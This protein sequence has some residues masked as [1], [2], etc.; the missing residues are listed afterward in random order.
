MIDNIP[1]RC[2]YKRNI[3]KLRIILTYMSHGKW[4]RNGIAIIRLVLLSQVFLNPVVLHLLIKVSYAITA[5]ISIHSFNLEQN[6]KG[7]KGRVFSYGVFISFSLITFGTGADCKCRP[8]CMP[9]IYACMYVNMYIC[10]HAYM[11]ACLHICMHA[12]MCVCIYAC[13]YVCIYECM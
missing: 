2:L 9:C 7:K 10:M 5:Q 1:T 8:T 6:R 12:C 11:Y 13:M 4:D 3:S